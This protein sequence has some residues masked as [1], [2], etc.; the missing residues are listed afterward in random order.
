[1]PVRIVVPYSAGG[2]TD[3]VARLIAQKVGEQTGG[4]F[5]VENKTGGG[6]TIGTAYVARANPDGTTFMTNDTAYA[7]LPALYK[8]LNWDHDKDLI[9]VTT[10]ISPP[11]VLAVPINSK[12]KTLQELRDYAKANPGK[13]NFGTGGVGSSAHLQADLFNAKA[14]IKATHVPY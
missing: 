9:P 4:T 14:G 3:F 2:T 10:L 6:G 11:V 5:V 8:K 1:K 7:M 13:L 12:F